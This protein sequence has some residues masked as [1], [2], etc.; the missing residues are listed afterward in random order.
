MVAYGATSYPL[1]GFSLSFWALRVTTH[2]SSSFANNECIV[3]PLVMYKIIKLSI[4][5]KKYFVPL[6]VWPLQ[7]HLT[8]VSLIPHVWKYHTL[9]YWPNKYHHLMIPHSLLA[10]THPPHHYPC[11][12]WLDESLDTILYIPKLW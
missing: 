1:K 7:I 3:S 11:L 2:V 5:I 10:P 8:L 12:I 4:C 9:D 6:L